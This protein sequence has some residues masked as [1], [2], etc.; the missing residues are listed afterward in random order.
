M[1]QIPN[2]ASVIPFPDP[3]R[4]HGTGTGMTAGAIQNNCGYYFG[5][6]ILKFEIY[7]VFGI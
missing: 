1:T 3:V 7:L 5:H 4:D 2:S 6:W